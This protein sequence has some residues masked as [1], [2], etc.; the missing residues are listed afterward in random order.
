MI[1]RTCMRGT[2]DLIALEVNDPAIQSIA[3]IQYQIPFNLIK[4]ARVTVTG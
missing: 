2:P 4:F 3:I 1:S